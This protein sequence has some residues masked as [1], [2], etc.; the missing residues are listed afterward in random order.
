MLNAI[1]SGG[2]TPPFVG[3]GTGGLE[4]WSGGQSP[5]KKF[6]LNGN[7]H[8]EQGSPNQDLAGY[9][10]LSGGRGMLKFATPYASAPACTANDFTAPNPV[11]VSP[12]KTHVIFTG[13]GNDTINYICIGNPN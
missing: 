5:A 2:G 12:T 10:R 11:Q 3:G 9:V 8:L 6:K 13:T 7:A 4:V 1:G